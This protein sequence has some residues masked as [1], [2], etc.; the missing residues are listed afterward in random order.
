MRAYPETTITIEGY[1]DANGAEEYND[2]MS[3]NRAVT[4]KNALI[5]NGID[6]NG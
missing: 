2:K 5:H 6:P 3:E 4:V 1:T